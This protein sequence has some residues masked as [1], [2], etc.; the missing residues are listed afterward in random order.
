[1]ILSKDMPESMD[2]VAGELLKKHIVALPTDTVYGLSGLVPYTDGLIRAVKG[3]EETKPFIRLCADASDIQTYSAAAVPDWLMKYWP[4]SL[5]VVVPLIPDAVDET[6]CQTAAFRCPGDSWLRTL[7]ARCGYPLYSTSAN[8]A[9]LPVLRT[10]AEIDAAFGTAVS[11]VIDGGECPAPQLP[12][13]IVDITQDTPRI[14]RQGALR[15]A[16]LAVL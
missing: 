9:G 5:S 4:G 11:L 10:A 6:G 13:T 2:A 8:R 12:S 14:L 15:I 7:I 3:R 16:E 1:M